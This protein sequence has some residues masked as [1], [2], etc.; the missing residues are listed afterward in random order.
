MLKSDYFTKIS[1][2]KVFHRL[3]TANDFYKTPH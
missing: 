3:K 1:L 2:Q